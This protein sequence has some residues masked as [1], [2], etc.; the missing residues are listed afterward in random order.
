[1]GFGLA[2]LAHGGVVDGETGNLNVVAW[3]LPLAGAFIAGMFPRRSSKTRTAGEK[4][5]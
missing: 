1:M 5:P 3:M 4:R 2:M